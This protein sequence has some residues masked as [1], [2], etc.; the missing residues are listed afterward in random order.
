MYAQLPT[1]ASPGICTLCLLDS[2]ALC[3]IQVPAKGPTVSLPEP[4]TFPLASHCFLNF[5]L[6][7]VAL[8][9]FEMDQPKRQNAQQAR[10]KPIRFAFGQHHKSNNVKH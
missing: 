2:R 5:N 9:V 6:E 4:E 8:F 10:N 7:I 1:I 3:V